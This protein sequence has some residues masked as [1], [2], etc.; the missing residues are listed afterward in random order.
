MD[1]I[2]SKLTHIDRMK[3]VDVSS[4]LAGVT[5]VFGVGSRGVGT[6]RFRP[7]WLSPF[8]K[9]CFPPSVQDEIMGFCLPCIQK[10]TPEMEMA[11]R[12]GARSM[13]EIV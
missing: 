1:V 3:G 8:A 13:E 7:D 12:N 11:S 5:E 9:V 10:K 6:P 2:F 4:T